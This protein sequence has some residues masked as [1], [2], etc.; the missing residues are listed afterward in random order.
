MKNLFLFLC[1]LSCCI[2]AQTEPVLTAFKVN[3]EENSPSTVQQ[4]LPQIICPGPEGFTVKW[5][6]YR[7]GVSSLYAQNFDKKGNKTGS[8]YRISNPAY[9]VNRNNYKLVINNADSSYIIG[10]YTYVFASL[11]NPSGTLIMKNLLYTD[12]RPEC[13]TGYIEGEQ[14]VVSST[15]AFYVI[16]NTGGSDRITKIDTNGT[17]KELRDFPLP[18]ITQI[19]AASTPDSYFFHAW[20]KGSEDTIKPGIYASFYNETDSLIVPAFQIKEL[21]NEKMVYDYIGRF[22]LKAVT[23]NDSIYKLFW[24]DN[25]S[26]YLY[27]VM[28]DKRG[29]ILSAVDSISAGEPAEYF[30]S[31]SLAVTNQQEEY[32]YVLTSQETF[33][34]AANKNIYRYNLIKYNK[35]GIREDIKTDITGNNYFVRGIYYTGSDE[36]ISVSDDMMDVYLNKYSSFNLVSSEKINDDKYGG[37]QVNIK[38]VPRDSLS[39]VSVWK[40]EQNYYARII[41]I[42]GTMEDNIIS[43]PSPDLY[44]LSPQKAAVVWMQDIS[45]SAANINVTFYD[46]NLNKINEVTFYTGRKS[47][48]SGTE[49][50]VPSDSLLFYIVNEVSQINLF[51]ISGNGS[52]LNN[53]IIVSPSYSFG[54]KLFPGHGGFWLNNAGTMAKYSYDFDIIKGPYTITDKYV[55]LSPADDNFVLCEYNFQ[56]QKVNVSGYVVDADLSAI[57]GKINFGDFG[58]NGP[59]YRFISLGKGKFAVMNITD[60]LWYGYSYNLQG[61]AG[62]NKF[63]ISPGSSSSKTNPEFLS[64][65]GKLFS[66]W[67]EIKTSQDGYDIY[68]NL[69]DISEITAVGE[70]E[71]S[72]PSEYSLLQNY[73]NPF[74][75]VT[76]IRFNVAEPGQVTLKV[77]DILGRETAALVNEYKSAGTYNVEFNA[78]ALAS[79][80]YIY[81]IIVNGYTEVKK[82]IVLK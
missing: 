66:T 45:D 4:Y 24:L 2:Y 26:L 10:S 37:N 43:L 28:F 75:P 23:L 20:V 63:F 11:Y 19:A 16:I 64:N 54:F 13:G 38:L 61:E 74:N 65:G 79:G 62:S 17:V 80:I 57:S 27:S 31:A 48:N 12:E 5:V 7:E 40:D 55:L 47:Y 29:N 82:M 68:C 44:F 51:K 56:D 14:I 70:T 69:Q 78:S 58:T 8:N 53:K 42:N 50:Y 30:A 77:Y 3:G 76:N 39:S 34:A 32:F 59:A 73:P 18:G 41:Y 9:T 35:A 72:V 71:I 81:R 15:G 33:S 22:T 36:F 6:D 21:D 25:L 46:G 52:L 60:S 67:S 1:L 49:L